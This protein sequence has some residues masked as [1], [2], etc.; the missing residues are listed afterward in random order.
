M[1]PPVA[2]T[3]EGAIISHGGLEEDV[4]YVEEDVEYGEGRERE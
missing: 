3:K 1:V 2:M 4:E